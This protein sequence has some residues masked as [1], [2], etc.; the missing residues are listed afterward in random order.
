MITVLGLI[1]YGL[2]CAYCGGG[3][4]RAAMYYETNNITPRKFWWDADVKELL[5]GCLT[6]TRAL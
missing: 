5:G 4:W 6:S 1:L 2:L 3:N